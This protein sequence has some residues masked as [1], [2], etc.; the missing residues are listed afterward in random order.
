MK[1]DYDVVVLG[2]GAAGLVAATGTAGLGAKT[3]LIEK[4]KLGGDCTWYGCIPSKALLRSAQV[5]SLL[6]RPEDF[7]IEGPQESKFTPGKVMS[8]VREV[9]GK[10]S[11]HHPPEVFQERGIEVI[12]GN[13]AFLDDHTVGLAGKPI[14]SKRFIISTGSHPLVPPIEGLKDVDYLTNENVFDLEQLP[15]SL[16]VL[17]GGPI[18][19]EI[20]QAFARLGVEVFIVE[21][22][23]RLL[24]REDKEAAGI[25]TQTLMKDG[26]KIY[27][28]AKAV[29]FCEEEESAAIT[30][31]DKNK[32]QSTLKAE[33]VLVAVGRAANVQ[34]LDLEKAGVKYS[35][36]GI[37]VD[38]TL[39]TSAKNI[40]ACGDAV[41]PYQFSHM[42]EYQAVVVVRNALF[43]F[44][45]RVNYGAVP[46]CTFTDP[47]LAH[48]GLT[49]EE[50]QEKYR[51]IKVYKSSYSVND[52]AVTD[53]EEDGL[54][55]VICDKKGRI[56]GAHIVGTNAGELIHEYVLAK[57]AGLSIGKLSQAIHVYPTLSQA[58]KKSADQYY[59][60]MLSSPRFK[61][62]ARFFV[63]VMR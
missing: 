49:E 62:L 46:W 27:T 47:E 43:P 5:F 53:L 9:I 52:R 4:A 61:R 12:F 26:I 3:A 56:L 25:L 39:C 44:K 20:S 50:A 28:G 34:G 51:D 7:G 24:F 33:K 63:G 21:M 13:A 18:G 31:E 37:E 42:A 16:C 38:G 60:D 35:G 40:Y 59:L 45:E 54:A 57:S 1:Y 23:D 17:G 41:G 22:A 30:I 19:I 11:A 32:K 36:K 2:G 10:I 48:V 15:R 8:H 14:T 6:K 58:V 29:R 55:K